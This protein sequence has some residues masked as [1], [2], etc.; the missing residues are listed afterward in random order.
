MNAYYVSLIGDLFNL[1]TCINADDENEAL[2]FSYQFFKQE[3][4]WEVEPLI[5]E[6]VITL[7]GAWS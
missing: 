3:L 4:G 5:I 1:G 2:R 6:T 7:E